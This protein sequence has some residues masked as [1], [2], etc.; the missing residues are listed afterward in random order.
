MMELLELEMRARAIKALLKKEEEGSD[1]DDSDGGKGDDATLCRPSKMEPSDKQ[2]IGRGHH[3]HRPSDLAPPPPLTP[4]PPRRPLAA[5]SA[6]AADREQRRQPS[7]AERHYRP[8]HRH[9][10]HRDDQERDRSRSAAARPAIQQVRQPETKWKKSPSSPFSPNGRQPSPFLSTPSRQND[11]GQVKSKDEEEE[12][13]KEV[14]KKSNVIKPIDT[15]VEIVAA[16]SKGEDQAEIVVEEDVV[17]DEEEGIQE[18][19]IELGSGSEDDAPTT[20]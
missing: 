20:D 7:R 8:H 17:D 9:H 10:H 6:I 15:V 19:D 3:H 16:P 1:D 18:V 5:T 13:E 2:S 4:P 11:K 12:E 14:E